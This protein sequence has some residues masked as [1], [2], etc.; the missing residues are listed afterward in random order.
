[1]SSSRTL[2]YHLKHNVCSSK[3]LF[4]CVQCHTILSSLQRLNYHIDQKVCQ[5]KPKIV[6]KDSQNI[7][8]S[9]LTKEELILKLAQ[10]EGKA[11]ALKEIPPTII[12]NSQ[13]INNQINIIVPPAFLTLDSYQSLIKQLPDL[14][15]NA[16][17]HHP[18]NFISFLIKE[19]NCNPRLPLYNSVKITN[20]KDPFAQISNG[21]NFV[22]ASKKNIIAQLIE[23]KRH[24]LQEYIDQNGDKYGEKILNRY[25]KYVDF[26]DDDKEAQKDLE[27][28]VICM[29]LNIS[30]L[31][32][33]DEWSKNLLNDLKSWEND[34]VQID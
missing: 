11:E 33:S 27:V 29:L 26:L 16:L 20:K 10:A 21:K 30:D 24:I 7:D 9:S 28:D 19:T 34:R 23:N 17:S 32:G 8:Y 3:R 6:L 2:K 18:S 4:E 1:M 15:H 25:Q 22:Y 13:Q 5:N 12:N 14:L 31:I